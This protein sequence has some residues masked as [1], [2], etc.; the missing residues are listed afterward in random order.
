[1]LRHV[2][3]VGSLLLLYQ[4]W[5]WSSGCHAWWQVPWPAIWLVPLCRVMKSPTLMPVVLTLFISSVSRR[6]VST[7]R[8][9]SAASMKTAHGHNTSTCKHSVR[10]SFPPWTVIY[11]AVLVCK[12]FASA[13]RQFILPGFAS[14]DICSSKQRGYLVFRG[15]PWKA[16]STRPRWHPR[17]P[18]YEKDKERRDTEPTHS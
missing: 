8:W 16:I 15:K 18:D 13:T 3:G 5:G 12:S 17:L 4:F 6:N 9:Q 10:D 11:V 14:Q 7:H 2:Y 1:M